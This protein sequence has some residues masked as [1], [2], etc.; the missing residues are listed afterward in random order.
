[1]RINVDEAAQL[2]RDNDNV[3]IITHSH[4]DGDTLGCGYALCRAL[5]KLGKK[6]GVTCSDEIPKKYYYM[7]DE[8]KPQ[9]FSPDYIVSVDVADTTLLGDNLQKYED[10]IQLSIDHHPSNRMYAQNTL[11]D[12]N[13]SATA[14]VI[15]RVI[16]ALGVDFDS[17]IADCIYTGISTDTGC[18]K[19]TNVTSGTHRIAAAMI[20]AG[21][22]YG[23]I[24]RVMFDTKTRTYAQLERLALDSLKL[25]FNEKCAVITITQRMFELSGSNETE[26]DALASIPRQIEGVIIG[27]SLR[28]RSDGTFK[29]S[30]RTR[31]P[32][33][34]SELCKKMNGG[35]HARAAGCQLD[36]P[37]ESALNVILKNVQTVLEGNYDRNLVP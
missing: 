16:K 12:E 31:E 7:W 33:D 15:Y 28:E 6:A 20:D 4:P 27:I 37:L 14:E 22:D 10:K 5:R 1:M 11:L 23:E 29:A 9:D 36:G 18:F 8:L 25:Y 26:C 21:A 35:G 19:Y 17:Y 24:N 34:A 2:L 32:I 3:L 30:V 13:A